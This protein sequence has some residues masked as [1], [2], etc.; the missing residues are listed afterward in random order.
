MPTENEQ[1]DLRNQAITYQLSTR[2]MFTD[3]DEIATDRDNRLKNAV[4]E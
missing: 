4:F 2:K 1:P 3:D